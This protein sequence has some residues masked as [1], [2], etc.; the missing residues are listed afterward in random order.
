MTRAR[1]AALLAGLLLAIAGCPSPRDDEQPDARDDRADAVAADLKASVDVAASATDVADAP[2]A[3]SDGKPDA[4]ADSA[5]DHDVQPPRL[6]TQDS[7]AAVTP[8]AAVS[9]P[10]PSCRGQQDCD[11]GFN[12]RAGRCLSAPVSCRALKNDDPSAGDGVYWINPGGVPLRAYCDMREGVELCTEVE[13][14]HRGRTRDPS[15]L[16]FRMVSTLDAGAGLCRLWALRGLADGHPL[17]L[18]SQVGQAAPPDTCRLLG[19]MATEEVGRC[20]FGNSSN[21]GTC[22]FPITDYLLWGNHCRGCVQN[23]GDFDRY[24]LQGPVITGHVMTSFDGAV[25]TRCKVR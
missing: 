20:P 13:G 19:F 12:C 14:E 22:G 8:D 4:G 21:H 17:E 3:E 11:R 9:S 18:F 6:P 15:R 23:D 5:A 10:P 25:A 24:M 16:V 1:N 7:A 2:P